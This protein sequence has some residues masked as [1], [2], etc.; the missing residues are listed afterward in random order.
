MAD[1][2]FDEWYN[3]YI[4]ECQSLEWPVADRETMVQA[5]DDGYSPRDAILEDMDA[6]T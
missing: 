3:E 4:R 5:Y 6:G 2:F 1:T